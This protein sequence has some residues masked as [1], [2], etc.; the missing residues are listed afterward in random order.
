MLVLYYV[1]VNIFC[2][3]AYEVISVN[4]DMGEVE[5][6]KINGY[7]ILFSLI[8][9]RSFSIMIIYS[10]VYTINAT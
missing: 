7:L 10:I 1:T 8:L 3:L 5:I 4:E 2:G 6:M 9:A